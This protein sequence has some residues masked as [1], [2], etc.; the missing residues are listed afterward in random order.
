MRTKLRAAVQI[1]GFAVV[2]Y[3][4]VKLGADAVEVL[5][6]CAFLASRMFSAYWL[7]SHALKKSASASLPTSA[8]SA[9]RFFQSAVGVVAF[10]GR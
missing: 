9:M 1:A 3:P 6:L 7:R 10:Y 8:S 4:A 5:R 2:A